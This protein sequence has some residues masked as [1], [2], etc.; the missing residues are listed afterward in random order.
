MFNISSSQPLSWP[1]A[2]STSAVA[3]V[4]PVH[5]VGAT[6]SARDAQTDSGRNGQGFS[7]GGS[8]PAG[9]RS[10]QA[11]GNAAPT[12]DP[13]PLLPRERPEGES[14]EQKEAATQSS[15]EAELRK[16]DEQ[17]AREKAA[18]TPPLQD[19]IA[20]V[21]KAS[22]AVVDVVLGRD[23]AAANATSATRSPDAAND[24]SAAAVGQAASNGRAPLGMQAELPGIEPV[25]GALRREQAAVAYTEQGTSSWAPM[26]SG[27]LVSH[28]V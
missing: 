4:Q 26:E 6:S 3:H 8:A 14:P 22:A 15:A 9:Q 2:P 7:P 25:P 13:A 20:T 19:V 16:A 11:S 28:R 12:A 10:S 21:W 24:S 17:K 1:T 18:Q 23:S 27:S 5:S